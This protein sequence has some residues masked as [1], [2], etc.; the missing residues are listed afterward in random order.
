M[1]R[2]GAEI[3][4]RVFL[5]R[6]LAASA[7]LVTA[8]TA[9]P[10]AFAAGHK[11]ERHFA[12][13]KVSRDRLIREVVGLRPYRD[14]GFVVDYCYLGNGYMFPR[15]TG[16]IL[17]GAFDYDDW[18]LEPEPEQTT[19]MLEAHAEVMKGLK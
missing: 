2:A 8:R 4:R 17:G 16:I 10:L 11:L 14:E 9:Q 1:N 7:S 18:S 12:P 19:E 13:V 6:T 3:N 15:R 5:R